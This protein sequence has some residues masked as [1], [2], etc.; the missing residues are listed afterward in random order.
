MKKLI[1]LTCL[2]LAVA[3][4]AP[5]FAGSQQEKMKGCNVEAKTKA[6]KG[7]ERKAFMKK[8]LSKDYVL[9]AEPVAAAKPAVAKA[10]ASGVAAAAP[11]AA[12]A[13]SATKAPVPATAA[14]A[15]NAADTAVA[16]G[17]QQKKMKTCNDEVK[18]KKL[19]GDERRKFMSTCLKG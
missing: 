2:G 14:A 11:V 19:T 12:K 5:A 18:T 4:S 13:P 15:G 3:V 1:A 8:C 10:A 9:K 7:D 6:L 17:N 16:K